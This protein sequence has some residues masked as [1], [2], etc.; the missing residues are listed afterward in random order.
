MLRETCPNAILKE[1]GHR[2]PWEFVDEAGTFLEL[3]NV[4]FI[5]FCFLALGRTLMNR[6]V[7]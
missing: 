5:D 3:F 1:G 7:P 2:F 6:Q 4:R